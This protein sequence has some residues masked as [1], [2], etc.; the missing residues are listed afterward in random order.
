MGVKVVIDDYG[1]FLKKK[2]NR[3]LVTSEEKSQEFSSDKVSQV[4]ILKGSAISTDAIKLASEKGIDIV[5]LD[6]IGRPYARIYPCKL[7][8]TTLTRRN[9]LEAYPT[10]KGLYLAKSFVR[11]KVE[12]MG[13]LLINLAKTRKNKSLSEEGRKILKFSAKIK[14]L[15]GSLDAARNKLLGVEGESSKLYY[16]G[17][18]QV[19]PKKYY[20]G[21]RTKRP[22][23]DIFNALL[24]YGYGILYSEVERACIIAGLDPYLGFLHTDR[25]GKPSLV[26]DLI[27]E[28]RQPIVDRAMIT[29]VV[30]G[31]IDEGYV[32]REA[33]GGVH[34]NSEGRR[35][36]IEAIM[37]RLGTAVK[38]KGRRTSLQ[39]IILRQARDIARFVNGES[40][41]YTPFIYRW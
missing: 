18:E 40:R 28:F 4:L 16:L 39:D 14:E 19:I 36:A 6:R 12:N 8:G 26:L 22:P 2:S 10:P 27:E 34:L 31:Q 15:K 38:Y 13:Y 7:G 30:R 21:I 3:F 33:G 41:S 35:K 11:A 9:Q 17:I 20:S 25:Y 1:A 5:C 32:D 29:I 37:A 23:R 24:S